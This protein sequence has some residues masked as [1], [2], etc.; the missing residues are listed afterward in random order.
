MDLR[1][2]LPLR[3]EALELRVGVAEDRPSVRSK[4]AGVI[5][6]VEPRPI[7]SCP[8]NRPESPPARPSLP[9]RAGP[10]PRSCRAAR[11]RS[12]RTRA[13]SRS[14]WRSRSTCR[15]RGRNRRPPA[16]RAATARRGA[17]PPPGRARP[18]RRDRSLALRG[19]HAVAGEDQIGADRIAGS[20][21]NGIRMNSS[22]S[23]R[24]AGEGDLVARG[25]RQ[26]LLDLVRLE[27]AVAVGGSRPAAR[28]SSAR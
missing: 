24:L 26:E 3:R 20:R 19:H 22:G 1:F 27:I 21:P 13:A 28:S 11:A 8:R 18:L 23:R 6:R 14:G 25:V 10:R 7:V 16:D 17:P 9:A 12:S 15:S 2:Q 5:A 4:A